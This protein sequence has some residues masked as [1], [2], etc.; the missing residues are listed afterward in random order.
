MMKYKRNKKTFRKTILAILML[1]LMINVF[2]G[3]TDISRWWIH[4]IISI[5]CIWILYFVAVFDKQNKRT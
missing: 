4:V 5:V 2:I 3:A 1:V